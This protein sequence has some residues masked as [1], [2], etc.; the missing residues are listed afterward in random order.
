MNQ[1]NP[2]ILHHKYSLEDGHV[3]A[4]VTN[5][6]GYR[7]IMITDKSDEYRKNSPFP[8]VLSLQSIKQNPQV[9]K[10]LKIVGYHIHHG[11]LAPK[12]QFLKEKHGLPMIVSFR[13]NDATA[14][15]KKKKKNLQRLRE[16]FQS[17]DLF[18]PVCE[19]LKNEIVKLGC[20]E[21]KIR[22]LYGGVN[23]DRFQY[24]ARQLKENKKIRFLAVGRF[25]EKK[26]F[27][28][29]ISA[30]AAVKKQHSNVVLTLIGKGPCEDE[31]R[32][33]I[34]KHGL[35][36]S[37]KIVSWASYK[38][39]HKKYY[40]SHIFCAPSCT[41]QNG[42]QEGI[43]NTLKEAMATGMPVISTTHAGIPELVTNKVNG[44]LVPEGSV[45]SLAKAMNWM[46]QHPERWETLGEN[47]RKKIEKDF[48]LTL[49]LKKQKGFYDEVL[50][51]R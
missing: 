38:T 4:Q 44:L 21:N 40:R 29:L 32:K 26:G 39:I 5:V 20:P 43:P 9:I 42:N 48:N 33:L 19:H 2:A 11:S 10:Q 30:F 49:Q 28:H 1:V 25:V 24:R 36:G 7:G 34:R 50:T 6:D 23:L 46:I 15:P 16:L 27:S 31:Y 14:Y 35:G 51:M 12:F 22:V 3:A 47:A 45:S 8:S 41:D 13:G 18:L 17:G 37:V